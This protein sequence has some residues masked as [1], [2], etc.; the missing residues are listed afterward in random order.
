MTLVWPRRTPNWKRR[1]LK[2][3]AIVCGGL[4]VVVLAG[5]A[6]PVVTFKGNAPAKKVDAAVKRNFE[7][8]L[9]YTA[10]TS[11][12]AGHGGVDPTASVDLSGTPFDRQVLGLAGWKLGRY[13]RQGPHYIA[14]QNPNLAAHLRELERDVPKHVP[15]DFTGPVVIDYEPWWAIWERT[16]NHPSTE[17]ADALDA[18]YQDDWRDYI[19]EY[20]GYLLQGLDSEGQERVFKRTYEAF[21][22]TF[23]L[24]TYHK[25]KQIR[26]QAK[27]GFYNYP[28]VLINSPLTPP[29]VQGYG[30]LTHAASELNDTNDW[31]YNAVDFVSPRIFPS[32]KVLEQW[33]PAERRPGEIRTSVHEAWLS[34]MVRESVRLAK[35][36]PVYPLHSPIYYSSSY[37]EHQPVTRFQHEEVFRILAENGAAGVI[38]WHGISK[39]EDLRTWDQLWPNELRPAGI[40]SDRAINGPG[41]TT[42]GS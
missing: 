19:R 2:A 1:L 36:K 27:W 28:Q 30:D 25:C 22:R 7:F 16:P 37:F 12:V 9:D 32:R 38:I 29:G 18:D 39:E 31:L 24:A 14:M 42:S 34:S 8:L 10:S 4:S 40:N 5:A 26:P 20:R 6:G 15:A 41:G 17:P 33:P 21:V 23:L 13:R 11:L 35:G 3:S